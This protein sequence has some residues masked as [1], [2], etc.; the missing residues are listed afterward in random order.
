MTTVA[1]NARR[2]PA[3]VLLAL[4]ILLACSCTLGSSGANPA[5]SQ[6]PVGAAGAPTDGRHG[7]GF[8]SL[9]RMRTAV[10]PDRVTTQVGC[11][12]NL[13]AAT[14]NREFGERIG[15][16]FGWDNPHIYPLGGDRWLWLAHDSYVDYTGSANELTDAG[17]QL[18]NLA[19]VQD[20]RCFSIV[21]GGRLEAPVNFEPGVGSVPLKSFFWPLGGEL[22]EGKLHIFWSKTAWD[23]DLPGPGDGLQRHPLSTWIGVYDPVTL[24]RLS[25]RRAPNDGVFPQ[26]GF[27]VASDR[28]FTY[29]FGNSNML[30]FAREG[31]YLN[32]P[33]SATKMYLARVPR[34]RLHRQPSYRTATGWSKDASDAVPISE[35]FWAENTMQPRYIDGRWIAVT[36]VDGFSGRDVVV[37]VAAKPWGPWKT[38]QRVRYEGR[39]GSEG[40]TSYQPILLPWRDPSGKLIVVLSENRD[41]WLESVANPI[42]YRPAA[43]TV[44]WPPAP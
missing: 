3:G 12:R 41:D 4:G 30:N 5:G 27:A 13:S 33:H 14:L 40:M 24:E 35:R 17:L 15:P 42:L 39:Y 1:R 7:R 25:F 31:G 8:G 2:A 44:N 9:R 26:Y 36:K 19:F 18:Q 32:G 23:P 37:D 22:H 38:V 10:Q 6:P 16:L 21:H 28:R 29:L 34:G 20:G 11:L 43:F